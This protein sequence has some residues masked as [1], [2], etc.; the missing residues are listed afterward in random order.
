M[1]HTSLD[2]TNS[3]DQEA[4]W[5]FTWGDMDKDVIANGEA[6]K[7]NFE[8]LGGTEAGIYIGYSQGTIQM[9]VALI[10]DEALVTS[11][12]QRAV[13]LAPCLVDYEP[14][15]PDLSEEAMAVIGLASSYGIYSVPMT[16]GWSDAQDLVCSDTDDLLKETY[17]DEYADYDESYLGRTSTKNNDHWTQNVLTQR[18][19]PYNENWAYPDNH[20]VEEYDLSAITDMPISLY[21][22][23]DDGICTE[24]WA[25]VLADSL[26]TLQY[27][28][29]F[30]GKDHGY[31]VSG[32]GA[33]Y[34]ELLHNEVTAGI[35][36]APVKM[37]LE[38]GAQAGIAVF[39]VAAAVIFAA[40]QSIF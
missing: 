8:A 19:Q 28:Y 35:L 16:E 10:Q 6:M 37:E 25:E 1:G 12:F 24:A 38:A 21:V 31:F 33:T 29:I 2:Y 18:F 32:N 11:S 39:T 23:Q 40:V 13:L 4:Y 3:A 22:G 14:T 34:I 5:D 17:C 15:D 36:D 7:T 20:E 30:P 27:H 9:L 26:S